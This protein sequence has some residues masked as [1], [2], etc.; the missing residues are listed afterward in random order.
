MAKTPENRV[1]VLPTGLE[2][3]GI[4]QSIQ[5]ATLPGGDTYRTTPETS[6]MN[7]ESTRAK[8]I[9]TLQLNLFFMIICNYR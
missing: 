8:L 3:P 6:N 7:N 5:L 4:R 1:L 2:R 9:D